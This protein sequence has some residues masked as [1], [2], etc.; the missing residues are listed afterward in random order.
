MATTVTLPREILKWL[1]GLDLSYSIKNPKRDFAN[2]FLVAEIASRYHPQD[3][4]MH[5]FD[6]GTSIR[7]KN[8]NWELLER[9][10]R[11]KGIA[12]TPQMIDDCKQCRPAGTQQLIDL[13]YTTF[14]NKSIPPRPTLPPEEPA[15]AYTRP[16]ATQAIKDHERSVPLADLTASVREAQTVLSQHKDQQIVERLTDPGRFS[17]TSKPAHR[18]EPPHQIEQAPS[19]AGA[20]QVQFKGTSTAG[21]PGQ[22]HSGRGK[23]V[24]EIIDAIITRQLG[25]LRETGLAVP[26]D[27]TP[28]AWFAEK[29]ASLP[30]EFVLA[31]MHEMAAQEDPI[32]I[33]IL[34]SP[35]EFFKLGAFV[36]GCMDCSNTPD[37]FAAACNLLH[38]VATHITSADPLPARAHFAGLLP[39]L[40]GFF[41]SASYERLAA[42]V[43]AIR[44]FGR[45]CAGHV[46]V[47][48]N[49]EPLPDPTSA[50]APT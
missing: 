22:V 13:L 23:A 46:S 48:R 21:R 9:I 24:S 26:S 50:E 43:M 39:R 49:I 33:A 36:V 38:A 19:G 44:A 4:Q 27:S 20:G 17:V 30:A 3:I 31:A 14:T 7:A 2:G 25:A 45:D 37:K 10:F 5:S 47:L 29:L 32:S 1:Q 15:P 40:I 8:S 28:S 11:K 12:M 35:P 18:R 16:T 41:S 34:R 42:L 6:N